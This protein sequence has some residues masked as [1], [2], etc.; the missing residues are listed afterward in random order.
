VGG[1]KDLLVCR[2]HREFLVERES[3]SSNPE[4][5]HSWALAIVEDGMNRKFENYCYP[6]V[7]GTPGSYE[8]SW[9]FKSLLG[10]I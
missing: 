7:Q 2:V 1:V 10:A 6:I 4:L 9:G 5:A 3:F 8:Q